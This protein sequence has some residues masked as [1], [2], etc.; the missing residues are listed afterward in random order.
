VPCRSLRYGHCWNRAILGTK[1]LTLECANRGG[2]T[3]VDEEGDAEEDE[4]VGDVVDARCHQQGN[5]F[6]IGSHEQ[7]SRRNHQLR[8]SV[9]RIK[10]NREAYERRNILE[11]SNLILAGIPVIVQDDG[12]LDNSSDTS[13]HEDMSEY[14]VH[15]S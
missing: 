5:L 2:V 1:Q 13:S 10:Q 11:S 15:I 3:K 7:Q 12:D 8:P 4:D 9:Y 14:P 6:F